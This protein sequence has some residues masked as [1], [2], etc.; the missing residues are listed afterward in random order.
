M[1]KA[2]KCSRY[3]FVGYFDQNVGI[4]NCV[5]V[6]ATNLEVIRFETI[7]LQTMHFAGYFHK[8]PHSAR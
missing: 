2:T 7:Q 1:I 8:F 5:D 6:Q 3:I 4:N